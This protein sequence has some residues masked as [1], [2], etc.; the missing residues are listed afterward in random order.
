MG[1]SL[2][3]A[4][5]HAYFRSKGATVD[6]TLEAQLKT[7]QRYEIAVAPR[8]S[9][10]PLSAENDLAMASA[11]SSVEGYKDELIGY[12]AIV[13]VVAA[14][15]PLDEIRVEDLQAIFKGE[16]KDWSRVS[17]DT[18][19]TEGGRVLQGGIKAYVPTEQHAT[20][21]VLR[22]KLELSRDQ[23]LWGD[24]CQT[25]GEVVSHVA[26]EQN[27][28]G[29]VGLHDLAGLRGGR[30]PKALCVGLKGTTQ[31][32]GPTQ[33]GYPFMRRLVLHVNL[34]GRHL[35]HAQE[36]VDF[37]KQDGQRTLSLLGYF[38]SMMHP[39]SFA[40]EPPR[41]AARGPKP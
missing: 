40:A 19:R 31:F 18:T 29:F 38:D 3:P 1:A 24:R 36:I 9:L 33:A 34:S 37:A 21:E 6:Q 32:V 15:N 22:D 26:N 5:L 8:G 20:H 14:S 41:C 17:P 27:A 35:A 7:G 11:L 10:E 16:A 25:L 30:A 28:I 4:I 12:E 13:P 39:P 2:M 23:K